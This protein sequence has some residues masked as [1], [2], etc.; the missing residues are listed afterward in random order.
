MDFFSFPG[1]ENVLSWETFKNVAM[2]KTY[3]T[4]Q[5][6]PDSAGSATAIMTGVKSKA[7]TKKFSIQ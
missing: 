4:N 3:N 1:E 5:Q 2:S 6:V 7:G